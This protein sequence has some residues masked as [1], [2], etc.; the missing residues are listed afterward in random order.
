MLNQG[1]F[2]LHV[3]DFLKKVHIYISIQDYMAKRDL[4][5]VSVQAVQAYFEVKALFIRFLKKLN[6]MLFYL[7]R[8][9]SVIFFF[10][11]FY[12]SH[13]GKRLVQ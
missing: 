12:Q 8:P 3:Y 10:V 11:I 9:V 5:V 7:L 2:A 4:R 6:Y 13:P 1:Y